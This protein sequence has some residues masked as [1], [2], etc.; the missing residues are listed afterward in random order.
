MNL[1]ELKKKLF[2]A[3]PPALREKLGI[4]LEDDERDDDEEEIDED[5]LDEDVDGDEATASHEIEA[6]DEE[7]G[8]DEEADDDDEEEDDEEAAKKAKRSKIIRLIV[9][10][11]I[12]YF[13]LEE[14]V[15]KEEENVVPDIKIVR[16]KRPPPP[17]ETPTEAATETPV[18]AAV[19]APVAVTEETPVQQVEANE[20]VV[21]IP[22]ETSA[23]VV[24]VPA[25]ETP[26]IAAEITPE[27]TLEEVLPTPEAV[28]ETPTP[29]LESEEA[30]M[31]SLDELVKAVGESGKMAQE[32]AQK[33]K[34]DRSDPSYVAPPNY[35][36]SGRGL[37]YNC[38]E[39]HWACVDKFSYFTCYENQKWNEKNQQTTECVTR[40]V[41][42]KVADCA[43]I[44]KFYVNKP[45]PTDFCGK[46]EETKEEASEKSV[47]DISNIVAP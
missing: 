20:E 34:T 44:Q 13:A 15:F 25:E 43:A 12:A 23:E 31:T 46:S 17:V 33:F 18:E 5:E 1:D 11:G 29:A 24:E 37:V 7:G 9:V 26:V 38:K 42:A 8:E 21:E 30:P 14:F 28:V 10:A 45:E 6:G 40:D 22:P 41:Y 36:R 3:I 2:A 27:A 4:K 35:L 47:D 19:E 39:G 16:P 32:E